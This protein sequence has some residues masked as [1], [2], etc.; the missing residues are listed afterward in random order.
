MMKDDKNN[1]RPRRRDEKPSEFDSKL[2][3]LAR[4]TRVAAGGKKMRFRAV[5]VAG[6]RKFRVGVGVAKGLDVQQAVEKATKKATHSLMAVPIVAGS[7]E[8]EVEA[9]F[10]ASHV[11]LRP[12]T[13]GRGLVAGGV[14]RIICELAGIKNVSSKLL[15]RSRNKLNNALATMKALQKLKKVV[16]KA[17]EVTAKSQEEKTDEIITK[18]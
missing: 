17:E 4:V 15:S 13:Q 5:V 12:Q 18:V 14:T 9:D 7:I 10:G 11:L 3:D 16:V 2:V 6:D 1:R 8:H